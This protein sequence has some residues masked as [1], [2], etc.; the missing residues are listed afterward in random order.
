MTRP[1]GRGAVNRK[2]VETDTPT[3]PATPRFLSLPAEIRNMIYS[4]LFRADSTIKSNWRPHLSAQFLRTCRQVR[5]E[6]LP[7]LY[8]ENTFRFEIC[9]TY[10]PFYNSYSAPISLRRSTQTRLSRFHIVVTYTD[11]HKVE[12]IRKTVRWFVNRILARTTRIDFLRLECNLDSKDDGDFD[13]RHPSADNYSVDDGGRAEAV[14]ALRTWFG[15]LRNVTKVEIEGLEE[16]D[17]A[18]LRKRLQS[19]EALGK[20]LP[21]DMYTA[22]ETQVQGTEFCEDDLQEALLAVENDNM[23]RFEASSRIILEAWTQRLEG[24]KDAIRQFP[25]RDENADEDGHGGKEGEGEE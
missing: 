5:D 24:I 2:A 6:G 1:V 11:A 7:I 15:Q 18:I 21:T 25:E 9:N 14:G 16:G 12:P 4:L 8:G 20:T 13:R 23:E 22:L 19:S 3:D 17:A 10:G